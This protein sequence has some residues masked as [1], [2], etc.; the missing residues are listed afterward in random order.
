MYE[1]N[2]RNLKQIIDNVKLKRGS[3]FENKKS[4]IQPLGTKTDGT[5][6]VSEED[7]T[8]NG[9]MSKKKVSTKSS[10]PFGMTK[11]LSPVNTKEL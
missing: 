6:T 5:K 8:D 3:D 1:L 4:S 10:S 9:L 7:T 2:K 11:D